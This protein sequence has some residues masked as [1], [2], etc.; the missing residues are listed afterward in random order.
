MSITGNREYKSDVFSL[1]MQTPEY[2]LEVYNA[3]NNTHYDN[4]EDIYV[5]KLESS[6]S[7]SIRN[8]ASFIIDSYFNLYEH[9]S[10]YCPNMPLRNLVYFSDL[11]RDLIKDM[12]WFERTLVKIPTPHFV[13]FYNGIEPRPD[14]EIMYLS[15]AFMQPTDEPELEL[16]CTTYN[17]N[18]NHNKNLLEKSP[19]LKG[20]MIF[21]DKV[22]QYIKNDVPL[23]QSIEQAIQY[24][25][26]NHILEEFFR[27]RKAEVTKIMTLDFTFERRL[28]LTKRDAM[29]KGRNEGLLQGRTEERNQSLGAWITSLKEFLTT[30]EEILARIVK[31]PNYSDVTLEDVKR[32]F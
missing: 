19:V 18:T 13:V 5:K 31:N 29:E 11:I 30:P 1:L 7:L 17:I 8:D 6:F 27:K 10:S 24:C 25:I 4:P 21:I 3:L 9:Q 32:Y 16:K 2:A 14:V 23:K 22:R 20:Y 28:E 15:S 12:D 26:Q